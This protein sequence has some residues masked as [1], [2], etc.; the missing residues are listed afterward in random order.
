MAGIPIC[1]RPSPE[2]LILLSPVSFTFFLR[3]MAPTFITKIVGQV[4]YESEITGRTEFLPVSVS[5]VSPKGKSR[6]SQSFCP[7]TTN[8][9]F[10]GTD[11]A[12]MEFLNEVMP[13][14]GVKAEVMVGRE[15]FERESRHED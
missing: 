13:K 7:F 9:S 12:L 4:P 3:S 2:R 14:C 15:A 1:M 5:I 6:L 10:S 11:M 8:K